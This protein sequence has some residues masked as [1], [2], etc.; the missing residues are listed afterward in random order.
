MKL[1]S[2]SQL[3]QRE[4]E[5]VY[6]SVNTIIHPLYC[7][8]AGI[9]PWTSSTTK[10]RITIQLEVIEQ[11]NDV[12]KSNQSVSYTEDK[13]TQD[14]G[15]FFIDVLFHWQLL[16]ACSASHLHIAEDNILGESID[17]D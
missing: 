8:S 10:H 2:Q 12:H 14:T 16:T 9:Q 4:S 1:L 5:C 7:S 3:L 6:E 13:P 15:T 17:M 11:K